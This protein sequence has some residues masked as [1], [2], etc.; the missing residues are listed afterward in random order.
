[1]ETT[2]HNEKVVNQL[3]DLLVKNYDA[4]KG[5]R[6]AIENVDNDRLKRFFRDQAARRSQFANE[7]DQEIRN[8]H[9]TPKTSG[10]ATGSAHRTWMDVK[11][12]LSFDDE[13][14]ILEECIRGD[15][16]SRDEYEEVLEK[17]DL[18]TSAADTVMKQLNAVRDTLSAVKGLEDL[19]D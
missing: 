5:Y 3:N 1:M 14:S 13:E 8:L 10:S 15:K 9:G 6:N 18:P 17:H 4:E 16:A 2:D 19:H 11:A 12:A 7:L